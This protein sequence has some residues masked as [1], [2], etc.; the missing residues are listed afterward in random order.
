VVPDLPAKPCLTRPL[1]RYRGRVVMCG[2]ACGAGHAAPDDRGGDLLTG[3]IGRACQA[4]LAQ[5]WEGR[6]AGIKAGELKPLQDR[7]VN[8]FAVAAIG[9]PVHHHPGDRDLPL[10][11]LALGLAPESSARANREQS[12][13]N[14]RAWISSRLNLTVA[15]SRT[16]GAPVPAEEIPPNTPTK[17]GEFLDG[18][19]SFRIPASAATTEGAGTQDRH[20]GESW[21][22]GVIQETQPFNLNE[23][24]F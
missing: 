15:A 20:A 16:P 10:S 13:R 18:W 12:S 8:P 7:I 5:F 24:I 4:G 9:H 14:N 19:Q 11:A 17:G 3:A 2:P 1:R 6:V 22:P 21:H 23:Y